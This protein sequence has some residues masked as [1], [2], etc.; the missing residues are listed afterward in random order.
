MMLSSITALSES[1]G[2]YWSN[3]SKHIR[4]KI[5]AILDKPSAER[6][7]KKLTSQQWRYIIL[8]KDKEISDRVRSLEAALASQN[9]KLKASEEENKK[10]K[11]VASAAKRKTESAIQEKEAALEY[12]A[13]K[14]C[15]EV[16][17]EKYMMVTCGHII[18]FDCFYGGEERATKNPD[19]P[20]TC[21]FCNVP[22]KFERKKI[23]RVYNM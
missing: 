21:P 9:A 17:D 4:D 22:L 18:C 2:L 8:M 14:V 3:I 16:K 7:T 6:K 15:F 12:A 10:L 13:C 20:H 1:I 19:N 5:K 11:K 23:K